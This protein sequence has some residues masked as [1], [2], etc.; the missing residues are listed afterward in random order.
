MAKVSKQFHDA[1]RRRFDAQLNELEKTYPPALLDLC[2]AYYI[3][4]WYAA[5]IPEYDA[6]LQTGC[7]DD[8]EYE[9]SDALKKISPE[10]LNELLHTELQPGKA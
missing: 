7:A 5:T 10:R 4:G 1:M 6:D 9:L 3:E 2:F 8:T